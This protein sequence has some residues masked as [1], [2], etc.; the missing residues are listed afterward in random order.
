MAEQGTH[1][2]LVAG[3]SP[4]G[5]TIR[6]HMRAGRQERQGKRKEQRKRLIII[7]AAVGVFFVL[8]GAAWG[9]A[10]FLSGGDRVELPASATASAST[11]ESITAG[12]AAAESTAPQQAEPLVEVP[13]VLHRR[14]SEARVLIEAAGLVVV[15]EEDVVVTGPES[16]EEREVLSQEPAPGTLAEPGELVVLSVPAVAS[17]DDLSGSQY[18]VCID[19]GHQSR[20]DTDR[21]PIGPGSEETK[22]RIRGG[23]TGVSTGIPE[24][25]VTLQISMN[26]KERLEAAGVRVVMTREA[27]DVNVSN[28]ERA[29][30]ANEAGADLFVRVH[31]DGSPDSEACGISTLHPASNQ[32]TG[33]IVAPSENAAQLV[34]DSMVSATGAESRG[35]VARDD[36]TGFNW[37]EVPAILVECGFMSNPVEDKLLSS[38]HYQD[39]LA[40]GITS[41]I[42]EY[43]GR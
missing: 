37:S 24:Y 13:S 9:A 22:D 27:N 17:S 33:P 15:I 35:I 10:S 3:S 1:N 20:S 32:W 38:A 28:A 39:K 11:T 18:V 12:L 31:C 40:A 2:P 26:L 29:K 23:T 21:E 8:A 14:V 41:G 6:N 43:L 5:P 7:A 42:L 16:G 36:I 19:P 30:I 25:E 4:A 34:Q